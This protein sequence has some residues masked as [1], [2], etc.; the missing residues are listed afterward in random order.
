MG[1]KGTVSE[2]S[3]RYSLNANAQFR[4]Q[5]QTFRSASDQMFHTI[6]N[7][8]SGLHETANLL[9]AWSLKCGLSSCFGK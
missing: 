2:P 4:E 7:D 8:H 3:L 5:K 6:I 1:Q 9:M